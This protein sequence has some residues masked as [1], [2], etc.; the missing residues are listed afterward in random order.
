M[1]KEKEAALK[2]FTESLN[3]CIKTKDH[4]LTLLSTQYKEEKKKT[5]EQDHSLTE[6]CQKYE[7]EKKKNEAQAQSL[8][9]IHKL[10]EEEKKKN[11]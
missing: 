8:I 11:I 2:S 10:Y 4:S 3:H 5:E 7:E 1:Q 6:L 9:D